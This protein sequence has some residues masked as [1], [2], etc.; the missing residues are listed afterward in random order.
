MKISAGL[1]M[2]RMRKGQ[3]E[4]LLVHPGG[5]FWKNKDTGAWFAPKGEVE[6][7]EEL[8]TAAKREFR[9]ETGLTPA[10]PFDDLGN[11]R[12]KSGKIVHAWGFK[13]DCDTALVRSNTFTME[14]PPHSGKQAEFPEI[15][16]AKFLP[17]AQ[18]REKMHPAE[19]ALVVRLGD[20]LR[21]R[22]G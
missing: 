5:P 22:N 4:V 7:G 14:W 9:E 2:Y 12:H 6:P 20:I 3:M 15:D 11:V 17:I 13:G 8:L 10:G 16:R 19:F 1:L 21:R 18:A